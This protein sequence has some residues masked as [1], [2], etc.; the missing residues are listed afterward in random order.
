M[1]KGS[2]KP[3]T[4][5][6][7]LLL[8]VLV[9]YV[10]DRG[11]VSVSE[12]AVHFGRSEQD[13]V[14]A[15]ELIACA[16]V[17]GDN[18]AYSHLDLFD[19]DWDLLESEGIITL[20]NTVALDNKPRFSQREIAALIAGLQYL[21]AHPAYSSRS[22]LEDL[23][24]KLQTGADQKRTTR[25]AVSSGQV[26]AHVSL[27][28]DAIAQSLTITASYHNKRGEVG[29]RTLDPVLLESRDTTWYVRAWCHTRQALRTFRVD[30]LDNVTLT[31]MKHD[32][33]GSMLDSLSTE[34]FTPSP[35][36][37][38]V[39]LECSRNALPLIADFLP[40]GF[41][42]PATGEVLRVEIPFAHYGSLTQFVA[43]H[44]GL[45]T[46]VSPASAR[47]AV[48]EFAASALAQY[49]EAS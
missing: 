13:I 38:M 30:Y 8:L 18:A 7:L 19:I 35:D 37:V 22:D 23:M 4:A 36:D 45:V 27:L 17:P 49:P 5:D 21:S 43:A 34:L 9:P 25:I 46:V 48:R 14:K 29:E 2:S 47:S 11:E 26:A 6:N 12:A 3:T 31:D 28:N 16:G 1:P 40:R 44:P 15:V 32:D 20:W 33:H 24:A 39:T 42:P 10:L 41:Q